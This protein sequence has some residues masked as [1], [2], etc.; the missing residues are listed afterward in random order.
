MTKPMTFKHQGDIT[1]HPY[2]G[3]PKGTIET[4]DGSFILAR[5]EVHN[6]KHVITVDSPTDME[7]RRLQNEEFLLTLFKTATVTHEEHLPITLQPGVY[8]VGR[9]REVDHFS[10]TTRQVID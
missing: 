8:R 10:K 6:H 3:E 5:G 1:F 7:I 9:E 2:E 4:H